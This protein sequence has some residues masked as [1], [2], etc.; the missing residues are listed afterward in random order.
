MW[1]PN[2]RKTPKGK[3]P[4]E[5][6]LPNALLLAAA[7]EQLDS[8]EE[9]KVKRGSPEECEFQGRA[10][11]A[12]TSWVT[13][14]TERPQGLRRTD[15]VASFVGKLCRPSQPQESKTA[16]GDESELTVLVASNL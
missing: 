8:G 10:G 5:R 7:P 15:K 3:K 12:K 13:G 14:D 11:G 9:R 16:F 6:K 1:L 2:I 4:Q